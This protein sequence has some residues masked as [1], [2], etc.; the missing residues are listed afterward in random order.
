MFIGQIVYRP[1]C[2]RARLSQGPIVQGP[3]VQGWIVWGP[4]VQGHIVPVPNIPPIN[5][6]SDLYGLLYMPLNNIPPDLHI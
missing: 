4:I 2:L 5:P 1:D 3:I 6:L